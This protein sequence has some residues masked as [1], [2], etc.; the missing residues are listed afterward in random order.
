MTRRIQ[1][2]GFDHIVIRVS[3]VERALDFYC[4]TLGL[5]QVNVEEWRAGKTSF[6]SARV[7]ESTIIDL[8]QGAPEGVNL[9]H[10]CLVVAPIDFEA[11]G[12]DGTIS[13]ETG[14]AKRSGARGSGTSVYVRDPDNN[15][16]ELRYY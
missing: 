14:P 4:G 12:A 13:I 2:I 8:L 3:D 5:G 11:L 10:F 16:V 15:L 9:D 7:S 6:P 1:P